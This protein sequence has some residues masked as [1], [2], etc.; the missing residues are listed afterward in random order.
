[1]GARLYPCHHISLA[2][3]SICTH[4]GT[5]GITHHGAHNG[6]QDGTQ[7][8]KKDGTQGGKKDG[9]QDGTLAEKR[10]EHRME[11]G[12]E[13]RMEHTME[14]R[15]EHRMDHRMEHRMDVTYR[16]LHQRILLEE[17]VAEKPPGAF[18]VGQLG[19]Q[20]QQLN[21]DAL[22][23]AG[24]SKHFLM[25]FKGCNMC[26]IQHMLGSGRRIH[27]A[28]ARFIAVLLGASQCC[29]VH[30]SAAGCIAV[31]L[32]ASQCCWVHLSAAGCIAVLLGASQC[33]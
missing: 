9:T 16:F 8:G 27:T 21:D 17:E 33:C 10:I 31:L 14:H 26:E 4:D 29:W 2:A 25:E 5:H 15:M 18:C 20:F 13:H 12:M 7:G 22:I 11:H 24:V 23:T 28:A 1:M 19:L 30:C 6:T 32:G 3:V